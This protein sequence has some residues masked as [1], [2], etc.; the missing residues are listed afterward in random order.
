MES[1][2]PARSSPATASITPEPQIPTGGTPPMVAV[3]TPSPSISTRLMAPG[4]AAMPHARFPPSKAG[5][6]AADVAKMPL[7]VMSANS[8]LVPISRYK[9]APCTG[10]TGMST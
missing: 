2:T 10:P 8:P 5:P 9:R 7:P 3:F 6:A 1:S 4:R